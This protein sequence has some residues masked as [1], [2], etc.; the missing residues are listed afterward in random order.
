MTL[1]NPETRPLELLQA[2]VSDC[3]R[4][5]KIKMPLR[6][7]TQILNHALKLPT[8]KSIAGRH[9]SSYSFLKI[10]KKI[11]IKGKIWKKKN[12]NLTTVLI[13]DFDDGLWIATFVA[14]SLQN[15]VDCCLCVECDWCS[16]IPAS[17]LGQP[18]LSQV[19]LVL[20]SASTRNRSASIKLD[21][22][23][24][25]PCVL[26]GFAQMDPCRNLLPCCFVDPHGIPFYR[27]LG[28]FVCCVMCCCL[29]LLLAKYAQVWRS[30]CFPVL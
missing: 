16:A 4:R 19:D 20:L 28:L 21:P 25:P 15:E 29:K 12:A 17:S 6:S 30:L 24:R 18:H 9:K 5:A 8:P 3:I 10:G 7:A 23:L 1:V 14:L 26:D 22:R 13:E 27:W 11:K 2:L